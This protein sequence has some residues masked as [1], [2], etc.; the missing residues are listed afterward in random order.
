MQYDHPQFDY[1]YFVTSTNHV[2]HAIFSLPSLPPTRFKCLPHC[3]VLEHHQS[4]FLRNCEKLSHQYKNNGQKCSFVR[5]FMFSDQREDENI[6]DILVAGTPQFEYAFG[7][8][9]QAILTCCRYFKFLTL[10]SINYFYL[11]ILCCI[12]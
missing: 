10:P 5:I 2:A 4:V 12:L 3:P 11:V 6:L 8:S 7:F 9:V 1:R